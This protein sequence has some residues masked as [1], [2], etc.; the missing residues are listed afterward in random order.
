M[1]LD[2]TAAW[3]QP[4]R[5]TIKVGLAP[6]LRSESRHWLRRKLRVFHRLAADAVY[7]AIDAIQRW[8]LHTRR[9][10]ITRRS[11]WIR[12][13]FRPDLG[14]RTIDIT[15]SDFHF[16][17]P[18]P[19]PD[20]DG[21]GEALGP[22][23]ELIVEVFGSGRQY[24][25]ERVRG[26]LPLPPRPARNSMIDHIG[27]IR[28][29]LVIVRDLPPLK[30]YVSTSLFDKR[31]NGIAHYSPRCLK[32]IIDA[33]KDLHEAAWLYE[34]SDVQRVRGSTNWLRAL[35]I[36]A[37]SRIDAPDGRSNNHLLK[38][39]RLKHR[40]SDRSDALGGV[41]KSVLS[42]LVTLARSRHS[43]LQTP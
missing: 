23:R 17:D 41:R 21:G 4:L 43:G 14:T 30:N 18:N 35:N 32:T 12:Y 15:I 39:I 37:P 42:R 19:T 8:D 27:K 2:G 3:S 34:P 10:R 29:K 7:A 1:P 36:F 40:S 25:I 13:L 11:S 9:P 31:M 6:R 33:N 28:S 20:P 24:T 38:S 26:F 16:H 5:W 22:Q